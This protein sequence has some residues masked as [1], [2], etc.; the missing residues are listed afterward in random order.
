MKT[1]TQ[2]KYLGEILSSD[3]RIDRNILERYNKGI[4]IGNQIFSMLKEVSFGFY[5]F[6]M[7]MMFRNSMLINGILCSIESVYGLNKT[8]IE[9]LELCDKILMKKIFNSVLTIP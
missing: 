4:G 3:S 7:A 1:A 6:E 2:E 8:H 5:Y 9:Q